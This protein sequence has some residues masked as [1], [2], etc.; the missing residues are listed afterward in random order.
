MSKRPM[1]EPLDAPAPP[2][3]AEPPPP[4]APP[5]LALELE[6]PAAAEAALLRHPALAGRQG[7]AR[8]TALDLVWL[9]T[10][11]GRLAAEGACLEQPRRGERQLRRMLPAGDGPAWPGRPDPA[12][13]APEAAAAMMPVAGFTGS[14]RRFAADGLAVTLTVG[15][16]R[17][18][19]AEAE[20]GRLVL[21]GPAAQVFATAR[22]LAATLPLLP[23]RA[24]LAETGHAL[25]LLAEEGSPA[26][27]P[28]RS[29][30]PDLSGAATIGAALE[31]VLGHLAEVMLYQAPLARAT[32]GPE[33]VHQLRVA[34]RRARSA[35]KV[36]RPVARS[37]LLTRVE[38]GL[39][40]VAGALGPAR[41]WDVFL[42]G[43][44]AELEAALGDD[45]AAARGL[46][47]LRTAALAR[48]AAAY[49]ALDAEL[50]SPAFRLLML[51]MAAAAAGLWTEEAERAEAGAPLRD[52][53]SALLDKR[54]RR[55]LADGETIE[56]L[57]EAELHLLRLEGKRLRYAAEFFA[58]LWAGKP[59]KRFLRRLADLQEAL[60]VA[61]DTAVARGLVR[62]LEGG[63]EAD[64]RWAAGLVEG[65]TLAGGRRA[66]KQAVRAFKAFARRDAFWED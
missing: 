11:E 27:R 41:D 22:T 28:R 18:V 54:W 50:A 37:P 48:R 66:R 5:E 7:R 44:A 14:E 63:R 42:G 34:A 35:L 38:A 33:G 43:I 46:A 30:A 59:A 39:K 26:V 16:L 64:R 53:A 49:A 51:D 4:P 19:A 20:V 36:F 62:A 25:S 29:G 56:T 24:G 57:P 31:G 6:F 52:F 13:P 61:N 8:R 65:W 60:G 1:A 9:D 3:P 55:L 47:W 17:A 12:I 23:P 10:A 58:P 45:P 32:A 2:A 21:A 15:K 40:A